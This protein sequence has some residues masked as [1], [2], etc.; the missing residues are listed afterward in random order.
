M[1]E[2]SITTLILEYVDEKG[3]AHIRELH[4]E[5]QRHRPGTPEHTIR[6]RLSEAVSGGTLSR[7]GGGFYD[8]YAE[9]AD[10]TSVVSY[11]QRENAW[12]Q[13]S[14]RGNCDGRLFKKTVAEPAGRLVSEDHP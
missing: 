8:I 4:I 11:E 2:V 12:G 9:D 7:L 6:A 3:A 10:M 14:Y 1:T 13:C 5:I